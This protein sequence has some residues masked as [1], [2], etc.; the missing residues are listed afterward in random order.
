MLK[1]RNNKFFYLRI[2]EQKFLFKDYDK[3]IDEVKRKINSV[4]SIDEGN[5]ELCEVRIENEG[6]WKIKE[7]SWM[8]FALELMKE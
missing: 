4:D 8:D 7:I 6:Q 1:F 2:D 5:L 3:T